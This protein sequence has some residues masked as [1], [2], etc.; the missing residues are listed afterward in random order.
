MGK[1]V[2]AVPTEASQW[3]STHQTGQ[4]WKL[5]ASLPRHRLEGRVLAYTCPWAQKSTSGYL[6]RVGLDRRWR[7]RANPT[8]WLQ[9]SR[10]GKEGQEP[11]PTTKVL[12]Q[13]SNNSSHR[14][15]G[16][17]LHRPGWVSKTQRGAGNSDTLCPA[18]GRLHPRWHL[19]SFFFL[20]IDKIYLLF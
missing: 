13:V 18:T 7:A 11:C 8:G 5:R 10:A 1:G 6:R 17:S 9:K 16:G 19:L 20:T 4:W 14:E 15:T 2:K 12:S 3:G